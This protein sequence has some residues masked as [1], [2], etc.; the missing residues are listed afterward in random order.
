MQQQIITISI[1]G[2]NPEAVSTATAA[3]RASI[4]DLNNGPLKIQASILKEG[5]VVSLD[6]KADA[7]PSKGLSAREVQILRRLLVGDSN[8]MIANVLGITE[9]T[10][11][12]HL[13][14]LLR[15]ISVANRTQAAIWARNNGIGE[16]E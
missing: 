10:V 2:F 14:G 6:S 8:K 5:A 7:I 12:V 4:G 9:A 13:K 3:L 11:K 16:A 1:E 15:K